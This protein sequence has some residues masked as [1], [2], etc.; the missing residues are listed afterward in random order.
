MNIDIKA[1]DVLDKVKARLDHLVSCRNFIDAFV[2]CG[3]DKVVIEK[4]AKSKWE[5][6]RGRVEK[7]LKEYREAYLHHAMQ[8]DTGSR[9]TFIE[10][11]LVDVEHL[12]RAERLVSTIY[13]A[14]G[15]GYNDLPNDAPYQ[16]HD[17]I[18][19]IHK[20]DDSE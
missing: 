19:R 11:W 17:W 18:R 20:F 13:G 8:M 4:Q 10:Q 1:E 12:E 2:K 7:E 15:H 6:E 9:T 3:L 16:F 14:V 5:H